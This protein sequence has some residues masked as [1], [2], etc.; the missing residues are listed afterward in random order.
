MSILSN[1]FDNR[2]VRF[3]AFGY[4]RPTGTRVAVRYNDFHIFGL[5]TRRWNHL[6]WALVVSTLISWG[7]SLRVEGGRMRRCL[8]DTLS[9]WAGKEILSGGHALW[10][11]LQRLNTLFFLLNCFRRPPPLSI[12]YKGRISIK[13]AFIS[14]FSHSKKKH[15]RTL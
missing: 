12:P 9:R 4:D 10:K 11:Y 15:T 6:S 5:V 1:A 14:A 3:R 2:V 13:P 8:E 7:Q